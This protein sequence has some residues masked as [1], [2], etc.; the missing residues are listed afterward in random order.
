MLTNGRGKEWDRERA[1]EDA[2]PEQ[3]DECAAVYA[4]VAWRAGPVAEER[5]S[6]A[7]CSAVDDDDVIGSDP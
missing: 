7:R 4:L 5:L 2:V 6:I 1:V 3:P